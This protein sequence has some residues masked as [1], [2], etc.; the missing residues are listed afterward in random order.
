LMAEME[1]ADIPCL[2]S[3]APDDRL[4]EIYWVPPVPFPFGKTCLKIGGD[5]KNAVAVEEGDLIDWFHTDGAPDEI[6]ALENSLRA[7]LPSANIASMT[8]SPCVI[9]RTPSG[10]PHIGWVDDGIAVAIGGNGSAAKS[11]DELGRLA[12][13]LFSD[14]GWTDELDA[15]LFEPEFA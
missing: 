3:E 10:Y 8:T 12:A 14:A 6:D 15:A 1:A 2:I 13:T 9:T 5:M 11:S 7:M 4:H